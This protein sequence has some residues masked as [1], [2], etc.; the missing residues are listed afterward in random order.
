MP[1]K[2]SLAETHPNL[3]AQWHPT[4]NGSFTPVLGLFLVA[5]MGL[6]VTTRWKVLSRGLVATFFA[7]MMVGHLVFWAGYVLPDLSGE[8]VPH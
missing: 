6:F 3:V 1:P 7:S 5:T 8:G 2:R 4:K